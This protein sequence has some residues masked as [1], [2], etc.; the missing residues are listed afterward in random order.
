[1]SAVHSP[2][3]ETD[4]HRTE[5]PGLGTSLGIAVRL[6]VGWCCVLIGVFDLIAE[7]DWRPGAVNGPYLIFHA[8]LLVG[9]GLLL[10]LGWLAPRPG[11]GGYLAGGATFALGMLISAAPATTTVCC[12][13][14]YAVRHGFPFVFAA[15]NTSGRWHVDAPHLLADLMFWGCAGL[16]VLVLIARLR[17]HPESDEKTVGPL[18]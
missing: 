7:L 8:L 15:H 2:T 1:M 12:L 17:G 6:F 18:P 13:P 14:A 9:G 4:E 11:T 10:G 5:G 16:I 3:A